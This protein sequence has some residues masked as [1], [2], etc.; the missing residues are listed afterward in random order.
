M[1]EQAWGAGSEDAEIRAAVRGDAD[2]LLAR[3]E[4]LDPRWI[5]PKLARARIALDTGTGESLT[6]GLEL[7]GRALSQHPDNA[8]ALT[9]KGALQIALARQAA[10]SIR[11]AGLLLAS[12]RDLRIAVASDPSSARA[13]ITLA[14]LLYND[15]WELSEARGAARRAYEED[16][17]LLE[18]DHFVWLCEISLQLQDYDEAGKWCSEGLRRFPSRT[19]LMMTDLARLA[20]P[21]VPADPAAGWA[22]VREVGRQPYPEFNVPAAKMYVA[23]ILARAGDRDSA[24]ATALG[25]RRSLREADRPSLEPS[26]DYI[27]AYVRILLR[28]ERSALRLL[29]ASFNGNPVYRAIAARDYWFESLEGDPRFESLV[30]RVHL[31]IFCRILCRPPG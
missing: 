3:A 25:A 14:D 11:A 6:G 10:D 31:P 21:G 23:A 8:E 13:W 15:K 20:S 7:V 2:S 22:L 17:F 27:E 28:D 9:M 4:A 5:E 12:E 24:N 26:L 29:R 19:Y 1:A 18:E 16:V 30:D